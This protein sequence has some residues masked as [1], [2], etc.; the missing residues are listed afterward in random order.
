MVTMKRT[1]VNQNGAPVTLFR[2]VLKN[3]DSNMKWKGNFQIVE[4]AVFS[5]RCPAA[6]H[7]D[8]AERTMNLTNSALYDTKKPF[9]SHPSAPK[10][11]TM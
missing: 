11:N 8:K 4:P 9:Y 1:T 10:L 2:L 6:G 5:K 7:V 3:C